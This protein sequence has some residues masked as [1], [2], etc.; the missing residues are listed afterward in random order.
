MYWPAFTT[1]L[2]LVLA[3]CC[4]PQTGGSQIL[5]LF[6]NGHRS[7]LLLYSSIVN[8]LLDRGHHVTLV[9]T[10]DIPQISAEAA[11]LRWIKLSSNYTRGRA[12]A[13]SN[14]L[15]KIESMLRRIEYTSKFMK[16]PTWL[17][18]M[19]ENHHPTYDLMILGYLFNDYQ[20]G[21]AAHFKCPVVVVWTGQ[22]I[23]FVHRLMGN[24]EERWYVPQPYDRNQ[25]SGFKA[26]AFGWFE[27]FVELL[28][29]QKMKEIYNEHFP[30]SKYPAFNEIRK[31]VSLALFNHHSLSEGPIAPFLPAIIEIGGLEYHKQ[32]HKDNKLESILKTKDNIIYLSFGSRVKWSQMDT[33]FVDIFLESFGQ[34]P[35]YTILWTYD[36]NCTELEMKSGNVL[37]QQWWPQT[38]ILASNKTRLFISH[39]GK[40]SI[41]EVYR[42]G[43][44]ILGFPFF[45]DQRANVAKIQAKHMGLKLD[46]HNLTKE[47]LVRAIH[48]LLTKEEYR[49]NSEEF[50]SLYKDRPQ[51]NEQTLIYWL[52]YV[53]RHRGAQHLRSP[54][55]ELNVIEYYNLDVYMVIMLSLA[56]LR[57][58]CNWIE[59]SF[60]K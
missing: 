13:Q 4:W 22:P 21:V 58:V 44:P 39:G 36:K 60:K 56:I 31:N 30:E 26:L 11:N 29:L 18:F 45:G 42:Y 37:C 40:G 6:I 49:R 15:D 43:K 59:K 41:S 48:E 1:V 28:A 47:G 52:E 24:P 16:D 20:L 17:S 2:L 23:G 9:T 12:M 14:P 5:A 57:V 7:H 55:L 34:Y 51:T 32:E 54:A 8:L 10:N 33:N 27:K 19:Q 35:N 25:F 38:L 50:S 53:I 3:G 46:I